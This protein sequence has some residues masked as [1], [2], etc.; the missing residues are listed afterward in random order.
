MTRVKICG[1]CRGADAAAATAAGADFLG[2]VFAPSPRRAPPELA[3]ELRAALPRAGPPRVGV[4]ADSA[5]ADV[6]A[7]ARAFALDYV[8]LH[9]CIAP[10]LVSA[11]RAAT[12]LPL[13][14]ALGAGED[15]PAAARL[16]EPYAL[17]FDTPRTGGGERRQP[18]DWRLAVPA[19]RAGRLFL[20]GG[21]RPENV[22]EA[23]HLVEP[24][25]VDVASGVELS[26]GVKSEPLL[27]AFVAAVRAAD[28][29]RERSGAKSPGDGKAAS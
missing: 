15:D 4:F 2:F 23:I 5:P 11:I 1:L 9:G 8:Q 17:L 20:A 26:P 14:L 27:R 24:F 13:I 3:A 29:A 12:G 25:A 7:T 6:A 10:A 21:L 19:A 18:F 22:G 28:H 16:S